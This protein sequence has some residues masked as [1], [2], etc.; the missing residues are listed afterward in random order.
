MDD[1]DSE[2]I[3]HNY[4]HSLWALF[5]LL[6]ILSYFAQRSW[7]MLFD[8]ELLQALLDLNKS[9]ELPLAKAAQEARLYELLVGSQRRYSPT[10][11]ITAL[12]PSSNLSSLEPAAKRNMVALTIEQMD[13]LDNKHDHTLDYYPNQLIYWLMSKSFSNH[14]LTTLKLRRHLVSHALLSTCIAISQFILPWTFI[15]NQYLDYGWNW[16]LVWL[17][18]LQ[19]Q[20]SQSP[21]ASRVNS[22][23]YDLSARIFPTVVMC[24]YSRYGLVGDEHITVL[25]N[26]PI[27]EICGKLFAVIWWF[28]VISIFIELYSLAF[29]LISSVNLST[30]RWTLGHRYWPHARKQ[31]DVIASFRYKRA[32]LLGEQSNEKSSK[33][34]KLSKSDRLSENDSQLENDIDIYYLLYL[35]Y[36]RLKSSKSKVEQVIQM[37]GGALCVYL[38][39]PNQ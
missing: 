1:N 32:L 4:M 29:V 34:D 38:D 21:D 15:G 12:G 11:A 20:M 30:L 25:C 22:I 28:V 24:P 35:L 10:V 2:V 33:M 17:E 39:K 31:A 8:N 3:N 6:A 14:H 23:D 26:V 7:A 18:H 5:I 19:L 27:N 9:R 37:T 36:L 13:R 16:L